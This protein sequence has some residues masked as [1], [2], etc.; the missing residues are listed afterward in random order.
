MSSNRPIHKHDEAPTDRIT[1]VVILLAADDDA[2]YERVREKL[3]AFDFSAFS[4]DLDVQTG[5][6]V[7]MDDHEPPKREPFN[8]LN[9]LDIVGYVEDFHIP[10]DVDE[11]IHLTAKGRAGAEALRAGLEDEQ[12]AALNEV[13]SS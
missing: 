12:A 3:D 7:A 9:F 10:V 13:V 1:D 6:P 5:P 8:S 2:T 4:F 11:P